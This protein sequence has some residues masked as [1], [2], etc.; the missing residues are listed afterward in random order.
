MQ[1][2]VIAPL[3]EMIIG[4]PASTQSEGTHLSYANRYFYG[5]NSATLVP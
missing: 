5:L 1:E 3:L 2:E 4:L